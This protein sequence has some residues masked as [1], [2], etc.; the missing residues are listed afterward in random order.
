MANRTNVCPHTKNFMHAGFWRA[1]S[2]CWLIALQCLALLAGIALSPSPS[3]AQAQP[4][5]TTWQYDN[6]RSGQNTKETILTPSNVNSTQF[7]KLFSLTVDDQVFAQPLYVP[8]LVIPGRGTHNVLF[9]ATESDT[10]YAFDA[11]SNTGANATPL[12]KVSLGASPV[13]STEVGCDDIQPNIGITATPVIDTSTNTMYV[14][15]KSNDSGTYVHRLHALDITTGAEK[16]PGPI[17][18]DATVNGTGDGSVPGPN[19][20]Q[21][22]FSTMALT[23]HSRPGLLLSNGTVYIA[24]ASHCDNVPYHGWLF[25]YNASTLARQAVFV[26]T[27]NGGEGGFW[28]SGAGIAADSSGNIFLVT[29]NGTFDTTNTPATMWGDSILKLAMTGNSFSVLDYFTPYDQANLNLHDSDLGSGGIVLLPNQPGAVHPN[30]L[31]EAGKKG[32][33]YVIDRDQMTTNNTHYC[34][35]G[36][37][38]DSQIAQE[39]QF[40]IG[41]MWSS[42]S[43]WNNHVYFWGAGDSLKAY[44]LTNG[45]ISSTPAFSNPL[46]GGIP[47]FT[48]AIS[49]N[50]NTNGILWGI[51]GNAST[52][53]STLYAFDATNVSKEFYDTTQAPKNR[54]ALGGYVKMTIPT[55]VNGKVYVG[56]LAEVDVYGLLGSSAP[57]PQISPASEV[58]TGS[59]SVSI[60]DTAGTLIYYT[61]DGSAPSPGQGTTQQYTVPFNVTT[62]TTVQAIATATGFSTSATATA[63]YSLQSSPTIISA[64]N[65]TFTVGS[66]GSFTVTTTGAPAP[67]LT[68]SGTLPAGVTFKDNGNGTGTLSGT[69]SGSASTFPI[70]FTASNGVG[71]AATQNFTLTTKLAAPV[72]TSATAANGVIAIPFSYQITATNTPSGY[73][74]TGLPAGLS[75]NTTTGL[76]SGTPTAVGTSTI[77]L[78]ATNGGGTGNASLTLTVTAVVVVSSAQTVAKATLASSSALSLSFPA[79]T[80]PGDFILVAFD[81]DTN[82]VPSSVA[83]SQGNAFTPV[84]GQLTSPGGARSRVYYARNITGGPDTVTVTLSANSAWIELYLSEYSGVDPTNPID[85][86][87]GTTGGAGPVSSGNATTT[88]AGDVI[89]GFCLADSTC[90]VGSGFTARSTLNNNL[91]EDEKAGTPGSYA[92]TGTSNNGWTMRMVA[93]KPASPGA[94]AAPAITSQTTASGVVGTAFSYQITATNSPTSYGATGLPAGLSVNTGTGLISGTPTT[95]G[96][97]TVT[98]SATNAGG[99]G[100]AALTLTINPAPPVITSATTASGTV[101]IAFSYQITATNTPTSYGATGLPAGLSVNTTTGLISGTPTAAGTPTVT[102]SATNAGGTGNATLTLTINQ[103]APAITSATTASG[104]VGTAFSYQITATNSPTNYGATGLPAGLSVNTGTGLISGTPTAAGS[105]TV[106]LSATNAGGTGNAS[107]TLTIT[108]VVIISSAQIA[109]KAAP[110]S[111]STLSLSFPANTAAGDLILVAFDYDTNALPTSVADSQGNVFTEVGTQLN[112][113][114]GAR[115]RVY[116]AKKIKGGADT[117][118]VTLSANS[119][120]LEVYLSEYSGVDQVNPIDAQI[121]AT[122]N[123][124]AVS[125]GNATTTVAGDVIY[126]FCLADSTCTVGSG[127]AAR[128]TLNNNLIEDKTAGAPG[129][130]ATTGTANNGWTMQLVALRP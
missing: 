129:S 46:L 56:A 60:T 21:L 50:G 53:R 20:N 114:G 88:V 127:F 125:S 8:G 17:V 103:A 3:R 77:T 47:S 35:T 111:A 13:T 19:G 95:A 4:N 98:L 25:A 110:G 62:T 32:T 18:I 38:N 7:G 126:G 73:G 40:A 39:F 33:I 45:V 91:V 48:T 59:V 115:S 44:S 108:S 112:S 85:V 52:L 65:A 14:E 81:Y 117:V 102:L 16:A 36:C 66:A 72:I 26:P 109:A 113:P 120:W 15:T 10:V 6:S 104:A 90:T 84:G 121:G 12:W 63:T 101:G 80:A 55:V 27:L 64:N 97:S 92:A 41:G 78:S 61:T 43:Y 106:T 71:T 34:T 49:S 37:S 5:M 116:Y 67:S 100:N 29:G 74:A 51:L 69:A 124:G 94:G 123:A 122:G 87:A 79:N 23:H 96:T 119:A 118:T 82:A 11:D 93:L 130:Y 1:S 99:T 68:E 58:F 9:I 75:V 54:D 42:P 30:L 105:T 89:Y 86:Q 76:I 57:T 28:M 31:V 24:F 83:D 70:T 2:A 107:L 128:S 22:T